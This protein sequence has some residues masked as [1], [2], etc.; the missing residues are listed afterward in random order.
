MRLAIL[1]SHNGSLVQVVI[2]AITS[3]SLPVE[4]A[5]V[6][7]NNGQSNALLRAVKRNVPTVHLSS[8]THDDPDEAMVKILQGANV[9]L[10]LL[11]G[12]L[13]KLGPKTLACF[14]NQIINTHPSLLPKYGG[15]GF[16]GRR[17][18]QAVIEAGDTE[19]GATLHFVD[20]NYD[21][22]PILAQTRVPV[23]PND[24]AEIVESRVKKAERELLLRT[25]KTI[26]H[27]P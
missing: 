2:N 6:I 18:H 14:P 20:A 21:T 9:D 16:Y 7:S 19:S 24:I 25:L 27:L 8:K 3:Q 26:A 13:K 12:Y 11:A 5:L 15:Q 17:V 22:G 1:A 23:Y 10:I 4:L